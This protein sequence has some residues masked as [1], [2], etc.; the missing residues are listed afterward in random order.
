MI[1]LYFPYPVLFLLYFIFELVDV[2]E[3]ISLVELTKLLKILKEELSQSENIEID[4]I[5]EILLDRDKTTMSY[6]VSSSH[7]G[8]SYVEKY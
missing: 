5:F 3:L 4:D 6:F 1:K 7:I 8:K 2:F